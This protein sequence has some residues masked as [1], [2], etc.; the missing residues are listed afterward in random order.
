M[1]WLQC[2]QVSRLMDIII[3]SLYSNREVFLRELISNAND[4]IDKIRFQSLTDSSALDSDANLDIRIS[5]DPQE[6]TITVV[7]TGIGMTKKELITNLGTIAKSGTSSFLD[8]LSE[9]QTQGGT[10][11]A[12]LIGQFGVGFYSCFLVADQVTV[13]SKNNND[14]QWRWTSRAESGFTITEDKSQSLGT[15]LSCTQAFSRSI[16]P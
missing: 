7:D 11:T 9:D 10:K 16:A 6:R 2:L 1:S 8:Q 12:N 15:S 14:T 5:V 3:H 13:I 4:A